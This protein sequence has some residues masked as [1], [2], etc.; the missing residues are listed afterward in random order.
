MNDA[1]STQWTLGVTFGLPIAGLAVTAL[2][3]IVVTGLVLVIRN[4]N[5]GERYN[6][7]HGWRRWP[8]RYRGV[9][10]SVPAATVLC[11]LLVILG[12]RYWPWSAAYHQYRP[13]TGTVA[14]IGDRINQ[15]STGNTVVQLTSGPQ[16]YDVL[17]AR[18]SLLK[19]GDLVYLRCIRVWDYGSNNAGYSCKWGQ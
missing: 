4:R 13:V 15:A 19:L 7:S 3:A 18:G 9:A 14:K 16:Q 11:I 10:M 17:D 2:L 8:D 6:S 1:T 12:L 5:E